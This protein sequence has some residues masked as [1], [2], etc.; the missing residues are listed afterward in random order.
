[1]DDT[2]PVIHQESEIRPELPPFDPEAKRTS[3]PV[4]DGTDPIKKAA[5]VW[6]GIE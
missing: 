2:E 6:E 5:A 4:G 3:V 1:M